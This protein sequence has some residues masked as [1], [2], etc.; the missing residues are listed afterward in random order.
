[1]T[2]SPYFFLSWIS[3]VAFSFLFSI[4]AFDGSFELENSIQGLV[5]IYLGA[6]VGHLL[7]WLVCKFLGKDSE[8]SSAKKQLLF[9]FSSLG[10]WSLYFAVFALYARLG[11]AIVLSS[12]LLFITAPLVVQL[13]VRERSASKSKI[14]P[15]SV[16]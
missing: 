13:V 10:V 14:S 7:F 2:R 8:M 3:G 1:M 11:I 15:T 9:L 12:A 6:F 5:R 16:S 4:A